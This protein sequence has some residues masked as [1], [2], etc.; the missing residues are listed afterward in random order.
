[1]QVTHTILYLY[2]NI[3]FIDISYKA[4]TTYI[5]SNHIMCC[6][7]VFRHLAVLWELDVELPFP[8][9]LAMV[10]PA[11]KNSFFFGVAKGSLSGNQMHIWVF[12]KIGVP[13]NGWFIMENPIKMDDLGVPLFSETSI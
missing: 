7:A 11:T 9:E 6:A 1:M 4:V 5:N 8:L 10:Q 12:P 3:K 13:Q 2:I